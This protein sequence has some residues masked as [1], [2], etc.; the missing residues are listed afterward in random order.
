MIPTLQRQVMYFCSTGDSTSGAGG[1]I[2]GL[3][4]VLVASGGAIVDLLALPER[5]NMAEPFIN[6]YSTIGTTDA[7]KLVSI[8]CRLQHG[9]S[10]A[11]GDMADFSTGSTGTWPVAR[12]LFTTAE[13]TT[14]VHWTTGAIMLS[15]NPGGYDINGANRYLRTVGNVTL[16]TGYRTSTSTAGSVDNMYVTGG[17][18]LGQCQPE[19][20]ANDACSTST[21]TST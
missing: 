18:R 2:T 19:P 12:N 20:P 13:T 17:I 6:V 15:S 21:S 1:D 16:S 11:G 7:S 3:G 9:A 8:V 10:S 5:Y 14:M 4:T